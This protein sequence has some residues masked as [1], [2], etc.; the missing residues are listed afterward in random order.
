MIIK[1][2]SAKKYTKIYFE[3]SLKGGKQ[4]C[5]F[6]FYFFKYIFYFQKYFLRPISPN[7]SE[8]IGNNVNTMECIDMHKIERERV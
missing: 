2:Y 4:T 3:I 1:K 5:Y 7:K 6:C 8:S